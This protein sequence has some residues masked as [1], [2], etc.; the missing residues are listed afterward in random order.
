MLSYLQYG[1]A[2]GNANEICMD[3]DDV[4]VMMSIFDI[5]AIGQNDQ[6]IASIM[7]WNYN[8]NYYYYYYYYYNYYYCSHYYYYTQFKS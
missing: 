8:Y 5:N 6:S 2:N 1:N 3:D 7:R 4:I